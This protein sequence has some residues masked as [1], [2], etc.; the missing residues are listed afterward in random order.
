MEGTGTRLL[1]MRTCWDEEILER[2]A[3]CLSQARRPRLTL[4]HSGAVCGPAECGPYLHS[5]HEVV[6]RSVEEAASSHVFP[7]PGVAVRTCVSSWVGSHCRGL[8]SHR[9]ALSPCRV[10]ARLDF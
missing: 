7:G 9:R 4:W 8:R 5:S 1:G 2:Q 10:T 3:A 6:A